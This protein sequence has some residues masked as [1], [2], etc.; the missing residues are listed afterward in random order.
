MPR[1]DLTDDEHEAIAKALRKLIDADRYP[2]SPR[3]RP[4]KSALAKLA[5][6]PAKRPLP[7]PPKP[8]DGPRYG[9]GGSAKRTR[10]NPLAVG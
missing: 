10:R 1:I 5:P 7:P 2:F 3:L 8:G 9:K 6:Q 4:L